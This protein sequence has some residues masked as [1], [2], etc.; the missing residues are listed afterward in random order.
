MEHRYLARVAAHHAG[1][2]GSAAEVRV[3]LL[4][5]NADQLQNVFS[6]FPASYF[7][8][9]YNIA[10]WQWELAAFRPDWFSSSPVQ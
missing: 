5:A 10:V 4:F 3:N 9:A 1:R 2:A 6:L 8:D 7:D